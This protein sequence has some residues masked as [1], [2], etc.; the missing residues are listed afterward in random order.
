M[1]IS[2]MHFEYTFSVFPEYIFY[3]YIQKEADKGCSCRSNKPERVSLGRPRIT[4]SFLKT[5]IKE[6]KTSL[7]RVCH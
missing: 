7:R 1:N 2:N 5:L 3:N 4:N 6:V